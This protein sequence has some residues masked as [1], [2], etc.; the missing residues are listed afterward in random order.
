M[1]DYQWEAD[2]A[3]SYAELLKSRNRAEALPLHDSLLQFL[4][5]LPSLREAK[6][7]RNCK[8]NHAEALPLH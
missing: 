8:K 3:H 2:L 7:R 4:R 1:E 6:R 5:L